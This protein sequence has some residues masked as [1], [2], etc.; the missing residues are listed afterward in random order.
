M[1]QIKQNDALRSQPLPSEKD[2]DTARERY[3]TIFGEKAPTLRRGRMV[4]Q[5]A[6][7]ILTISRNY[8]EPA[9]ALVG[10]LEEHG[11]FLGLDETEETGRLVIARRSHDL[12]KALVATG[13][14]ATGTSSAKRTI[15]TLAHF[16]LGPV[17]PGRYGTSIKKADAVAQ[18]LV[19]ASWDTLDLA[20][21]LGGEGRSLLESLRGMARADQ[22]TAD[23]I[24]A[25][26]RTR[27]EVNALVKRGQTGGQVTPPV[28]PPVVPVR[29]DPEVRTT[30]PSATRK[31][32]GRRTTTA[33]RAAADLEAELAGW[34]A[35]Q[36]GATIEINWRVVD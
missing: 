21:G 12:L 26:D 8:Q 25:L 1:S 6:R 24:E 22:R 30:D 33:A 13:Q 29:V 27:R 28:Q 19:G 10:Q 3:E 5:F 36:P 9:A 4:H 2:W 32:E 23:L 35:Q 11:T 14:G 7:Q 20:E 17:D 34:A 31:R 16:D 15:E 18:A